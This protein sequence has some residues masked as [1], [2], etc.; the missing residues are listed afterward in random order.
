MKWTRY[1]PTIAVVKEHWTKKGG[2]FVLTHPEG[3]DTFEFS[4]SSERTDQLRNAF[5]SAQDLID[6]G[7][8]KG[9]AVHIEGKAL[10]K[11]VTNAFNN[12]QL[13]EELK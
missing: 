11:A 6:A 5:F 8:C 7:K 1:S 9:V 12:G 2:R 3:K 10:S 4:D 13:V